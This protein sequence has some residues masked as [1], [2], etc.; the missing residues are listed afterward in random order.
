MTRRPPP[1][2]LPKI[3]CFDLG[4]V[5]IQI[6]HSWSDAY[7]AAGLE[8]RTLPTGPAIDAERRRLGAAHEVGAISLEDWAE[9]VSKVTERVYTPDEMKRAHYAVCQQE[10]PGA[11][12]L[13]DELHGAGVLT[14]CLS[15]TNDAHWKRLVHEDGD[16]PVAGPPQYP[17]VARLRRHF[18]SHVLGLAKPD[19]AIYERFEELTGVRGGEVL[20]FD[21]R[22]DN[23][24]AAIA[25]GWRAER[26]DPSGDTIAQIRRRLRDERVL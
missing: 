5:L 21:D 9:G 22:A 8:L 26:I 6:C 14:A 1:L 20:F 10:Q 16:K 3:V 12:A 23:T 24:A 13:I 19:R 15:N 4:G 2:P 18:A 25:H 17:S 7:R 11:P